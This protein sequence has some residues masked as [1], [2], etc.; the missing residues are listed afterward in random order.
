M[1]STESG[2][3]VAIRAPEPRDYG[4][5]AELAGQLTYKSEAEDIARRFWGMRESGDHAAFVA[6]TAGGDIAGWIG[7]FIYRCVEADV[8][9]EISGLVVEDRLRSLGIGR[10]LLERAEEWAREKGC[11]EVGLR[12]NVIRDRAHAFYERLGYK[13]IKTQKSFR[14]RVAGTEIQQTSKSF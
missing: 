9:A 12:S 10:R 3:A 8:R 13:H 14:K 5:I 7:V 1:T 6:E 2:A 11:A 4:R